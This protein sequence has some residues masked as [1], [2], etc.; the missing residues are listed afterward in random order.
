MRQNCSTMA[1]HSLT[2][3]FG[4]GSDKDSFIQEPF[5]LSESELFTFRMLDGGFG[6]PEIPMFIEQADSDSLRNARSVWKQSMHHP[7]LLITQ[8]VSRSGPTV[9]K[10]FSGLTTQDTA[11]APAEIISLNLTL[12]PL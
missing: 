8:S 12:H 5:R 4:I 9:I 1:H 7:W 6:A 10:R 2:R 3:Q 11:E